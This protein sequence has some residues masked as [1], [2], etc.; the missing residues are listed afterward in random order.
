M[1]WL[2]TDMD[3]Y[4]ASVEQHLRPE[5]R[6]RPVG[7]IPLEAENTCLIAASYDAKRLGAKT[8]T[9][10]HEARRICPG[11]TLV[12]ARP[13]TYVEVHRQIL[14]S[15]DQCA[16]VE[17]VYSID[18]WTVRLRGEDKSPAQATE[19]ARQMKRQ[20]LQDFGPWLTCSIGIAPTRLLAKIASS[21][22]KPDGLTLLPI[23]DLPG[24]L[25]HLSLG[26]LTGIG[27]G[28]LARLEQHGVRNVRDLWNLSREQSI[29]IWGSVSGARWWARF[30]GEDEPEIPTKRRSMTHGNVLEPR[31]RTEE[32][33]RGIL[34][35]LLC[36]LAQRLRQSGYLARSLQ[37]HV[38]DVRG[39]EFSNE[40]ALPAIDDTHTLLQAFHDLW[41]DRRPSRAPIRKVDVTVS[42]LILASQVARPL[43]DEVE[44]R[45]RVSQAM[46]KINLQWGQSKVYLGSIHDYRHVMDNKIAFGR[47]PGDAD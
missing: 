34:I 40:T 18:E 26:K 4:F 43:F 38:G 44:K 16:E 24:R 23:S 17:R 12:K 13:A 39:G 36:K 20:L 22:Q 3:S 19:L 29:R 14:R 45:Q 5:L 31:F 6:G 11:I 8:G 41:G 9:K 2:M 42:G 35:R 7:V 1:N 47:I 15:M 37:I 28:M 25:E 27:S 33:A 30:H 32:G 46:D 21:L 10:V